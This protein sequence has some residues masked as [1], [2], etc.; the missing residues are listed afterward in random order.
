MPFFKRPEPNIT[1]KDAGP[2]ADGAGTDSTPAKLKPLLDMADASN[3]SNMTI[4]PTPTPT[5]VYVGPANKPAYEWPAEPPGKAAQQLMQTTSQADG[6]TEKADGK[7]KAL[8]DET[9]RRIAVHKA[10]LNPSQALVTEAPPAAVVP[11]GFPE[12]VE[13]AQQKA[14]QEAM[15]KVVDELAERQ[16]AAM[17]QS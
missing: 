6:V 15:N 9:K 11:K 13:E 12:L 5:P 16:L 2:T 1:D 10:S 17:V 7:R 14:A 3:S 4:R 8:E